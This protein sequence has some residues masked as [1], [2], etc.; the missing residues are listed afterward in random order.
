MTVVAELQESYGAT[1]TERG[2]RQ[3]VDH[4]GR[5]ER[6]HRAV[7]NVVGTV[8]M[9]YGIIDVGGDDRLEFVD[10]AVTNRV[11]ETD[12]AGSYALL[13]DPQ[14]GIET[15]LYIYNAGERL[16]C[17]VPP[18]RAE[19][20]AEEWADKTFIQDVDIN[21]ATDDYGVFGVHGPKATEKVASVLTGPTTP[22][23]PLE[24]VRGRV[25]DWGTTVIRTDGLTGEE[26]YEIVCAADDAAN[27]FDALVNHGLNAAPFGYR[28]L[29]YLW[30]E[31]GT[32]LFETEL[33]GTV[34][35]VLGLRNALD[36]EKGCYVGQEVVS[37]IENQGRPSRELVGIKLDA[38]PTAGAAVF[39]GDSHVGEVTRGDYSPALDGAIA[40]A[41]VEYGLESDDL[42]VRIDSDDVAAERV[43]LPFVDGSARSARLPSY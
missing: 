41:L 39:D 33:E 9:G 10:N 27:V 3:V 36:F 16:L 40:L 21:V 7:R 13:L 19:P 5:P 4:Y 6:V 17:F 11:P 23:E 2:G 22:E 14:G 24:F 1:F 38:E 8:E 42:T 15:E 32:P 25:G 31:A 35:N 18:G 28:T 12:G 26:G 29:E 43:Q 34:P 30:L 37:K 20:V